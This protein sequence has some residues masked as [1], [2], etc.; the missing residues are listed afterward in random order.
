MWTAS[1]ALLFSVFAI[2]SANPAFFCFIKASR[3]PFDAAAL[4]NLTCTHFVYGHV[5]IDNYNGRPNFRTFDLMYAGRPGNIRSFLRLRRYHPSAKLLFGVRR[6]SAFPSYFGAKIVAKGAV[7][8]AIDN[9]F[10][11]LFV[12]FDG[13]HLHDRS[14][15]GFMQE[16]SASTELA[17]PIL[18]VS[19][20][21]IWPPDAV[22]RLRDVS[23]LVEYI[24]LDMSKTPASEDPYLVSHIDTL[25]AYGDIESHDT[26]KG[27]VKKLEDGGIVLDQ[28]VVG[29]TAGGWQYK[30]QNVM[31]VVA[32]EFALEEGVLVNQQEV[33]KLRGS[34]FLNPQAL[35]EI[36]LH[37][38]TWTS[39]N[40]PTSEGLGKKMTWVLAEGLGGLGISAVEEDDPKNVCKKDPLPAHH[41]AMKVLAKTKP[42]QKTNCTRL[43]Y[44]DAERMEH[45]FPLD[46]IASHWCSHVVVGPVDI[47]VLENV[48]IPNSVKNLLPRIREWREPFGDAAPK[49]FLSIGSRTN[50]DVWQ[51]VL[52]RRSAFVQNLVELSKKENLDGI[53]IAWIK[54]PM[55][56]EVNKLFLNNLL[57]D[58]KKLDQNLKIH[59]AA[60]PESTIA[61]LYDIQKL[62]QTVDLVVLQTH[63]LHESKASVTTLS[64]PLR[65]VESLPDQQMTIESIASKWIERGMPRSKL[66]VS[67]SAAA[68]TS[69]SIGI[70]R[71]D[72]P[73]GHPTFKSDAGIRA[74]EEI[75]TGSSALDEHGWIENAKSAFMIRDGKFVSFESPRSAQI[76][77]VW[78]SIE[79][80]GMAVYGIDAD[81]SRAACTNE[82]FPIL[83]TV[84]A[85]QVCPRCLARHDFR[86]CEH[87]FKVACNFV[88]DKTEPEMKTSLLPYEMCTEVV[89]EHASLNSTGHVEV[90]G[91]DR[92]E[93]L[94]ELAKMSAD[95]VKCGLVLSLKCQVN[96]KNFTSILLEKSETTTGNKLLDG[97]ISSNSR[98]FLRELQQ[99]MAQS[100]AHNGCPFTLALRL[101][102]KSFQLSPTYS[103]PMLN[104]LHHVALS[105]PPGT[106]LV[107]QNSSIRTIDDT[108]RKWKASGLK[109]SK[110]VVELSTRILH[111]SAAKN[112]QEYTPEIC[113][114]AIKGNMTLL[115]EETLQA[116]I[117][118]GGNI[119]KVQTIETLRY[120]IGYVMR[121]SLAGI[122]MRDVTG[123]DHTGICGVGSFPILKSFYSSEKCF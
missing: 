22:D 24:Y 17:M 37:R 104:K 45:D 40:L 87:S 13:P 93:V 77:S 76:K 70:V 89:V 68:T 102:P 121:E 1:L 118:S 42:S 88:L 44:F 97:R 66:V 114:S 41:L 107:S 14:I 48:V 56:S 105:S 34:K 57:D 18:S 6:S 36:T 61:N 27:A 115:N 113:E 123:D 95:M 20:Q 33:C 69:K 35:N 59:L 67:L 3:E 96:E 108:I 106:L 72:Q 103:I 30:V 50:N 5:D 7:E 26:I 39:S 52:I 15:I 65:A 119:S 43:C 60:N 111:A 8:A 82:S 25:E 80:M 29:F 62:N 64:S 110:L 75:C 81:D 98:L 2:G 63:R 74:Q 91:E 51:T 116:T 90:L 117:V 101:S 19:S 79:G 47:D 11:G 54:E 16:L 58:L 21:K 112:L 92:K 122:S 94:G 73:L 49:I 46:S 28:I 83:R 12:T 71:S 85:A 38:S 78:T 31:K 9:K 86:K 10:D 100:R 84:V 4:S 109:A 23:P 32:G 99:K 53:E 120:K 55:A